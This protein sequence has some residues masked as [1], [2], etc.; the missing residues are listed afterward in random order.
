[1]KTHIQFAVAFGFILG[2]S[3]SS[4]TFAGSDRELLLSAPIEQ[5]DR[6]SD[7][8]TVLGQQFHSETGQL[9]VGQLVRV[10]GVLA[11]DGSVEDA[12]VQPTEAFAAN[13]DPVFVKGVV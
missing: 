3:V 5:L 4:N 10:Y 11:K 2:A 13:G 6:T 12:V 9:N 8:I 1:M 7:T